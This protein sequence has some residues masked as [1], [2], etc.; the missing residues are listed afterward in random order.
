MSPR[1]TLAVRSGVKLL[2]LATSNGP[3]FAGFS[4]WTQP[5]VL[6]IFEFP[7]GNHLEKL[8]GDRTGQHSIRINEQWRI[9]F[10]WK[11]GGALDVEIVDYH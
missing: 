1:D 9:C 4:S 11:D 7:P 10:R 6:W 2:Y 3:L 8:A 5:S